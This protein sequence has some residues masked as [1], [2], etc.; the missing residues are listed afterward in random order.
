[1]KKTKPDFSIE[2][3]YSSPVI[4]IDEVG[5]GAFAGPV[6]AAAAVAKSTTFDFKNINDSKLLRRLEREALVTYIHEH[7]DV[8]I[9]VISVDI[10]NEINILNSTFKAMLLAVS[11]LPDPNL[12]IIIDGD[13]IPKGF[14]NA[15]AIVKG[16]QKSVS[17]AAASIIAKV[18]R[19][20]IMEELAKEFP[21]YKWEQNAGYGTKQHREAILQH[22]PTL[23]HRK[24]YISKVLTRQMILV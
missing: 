9:G 11:K 6:V 22:G 18:Y 16:D 3:S 15:Q 19:D 4:G 7:F 8:G 20:K 1:M 24:A 5:R 13:Q 21:L 2:N 14:S 23:H 17:I 10:I 12:P